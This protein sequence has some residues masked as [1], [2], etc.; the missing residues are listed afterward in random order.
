MAPGVEYG[1]F[2]VAVPRGTVHGHLLTVDLTDPRVSVDLLYPDAVGARAPV[3]PTGRRTGRGGGRERRLLQHH[4]D[5]APG[6]E[7]TG[8]SVGPAI[9]SG[10]S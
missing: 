4:R 1:E 6:V 7:A 10:G 9:S 8:A 5:P 2:R 3:S